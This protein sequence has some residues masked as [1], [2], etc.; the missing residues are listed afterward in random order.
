MKLKY[1]IFY[2]YPLLSTIVGILYGLLATHS[3]VSFAIIGIFIFCIDV[4][5]FVAGLL[6]DD[7]TILKASAII[8]TCLVKVQQ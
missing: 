7:E 5:I 8:F 1:Q 4:V 2:T 6:T 3:L